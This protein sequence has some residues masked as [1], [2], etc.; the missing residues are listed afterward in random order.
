MTVYADMLLGWQLYS[1]RVALLQSVASDIQKLAPA[2]IVAGLRNKGL[3]T[4][5]ASAI[6]LLII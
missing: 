2:H 5:K 6:L 3:G 4:L 1:Q